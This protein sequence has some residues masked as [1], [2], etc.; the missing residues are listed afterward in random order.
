MLL[1]E[2]FQT[3]F[4]YNNNKLKEKKEKN[5]KKTTNKKTAGGTP[6]THT[7]RKRVVVNYLVIAV[8]NSGDILYAILGHMYHQKHP[9]GVTPSE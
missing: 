8:G 4:Y 5:G 9:N 1:Q 7:L 2:I 6:E 3:P